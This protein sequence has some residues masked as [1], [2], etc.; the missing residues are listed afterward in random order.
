MEVSRFR[1]DRGRRLR[2]ALLA[3]ATAV[4]LG[5]SAFAA[6]GGSIGT[7]IRG[8]DHA[9]PVVPDAHAAAR[10]AATAGTSDG[11]KG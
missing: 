6:T 10:T 4:M 3:I 5:G 7:W 11:G 8:R 1:A 2:V 9:V